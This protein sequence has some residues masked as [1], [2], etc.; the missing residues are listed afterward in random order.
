MAGEVARPGG[1]GAG[2][3]AQDTAA[4]A[5]AG[6]TAASAAA[7]GDLARGPDAARAALADRMR[8]AGLAGRVVEAAFRAVP[9]HLFVPEMPP[10]QAYQDEAFVI[11]SDAA[12]FPVSSSS[13]PAMMAIM[14]EQL[15][16][17]AGQRVLEI[18]SGTGYNAALIAH[19]VGAQC[20]VITVD[21]DPELASRAKASLAAAGYGGITVVCG[22]GGLGVAEHAP[23]DRI[24]L[25]VGAWD[26]APQ[27]LAQLA[28]GGR[29]VLPLS[30]RGIQLSVALERADD[31]HW[32][33]RSAFRCGFIKMGG[34]FS[35]PESFVP[36]G[37]QPGWRAAADDERRLDT[38]ALHQA[39]TGPGT[40][41]PTGLRPASL[42]EAADLDLWLTLTEPDLLRLTL[43]DA[44]SGPLKRPPL[45]PMGGLARPGGPDGPL[46]VAAV[47]PTAGLPSFSSPPSGLAPSGPAEPEPGEPGGVPAAPG[48][49]LRGHGPGGAVLAR[50]LAERALAWQELGRPGAGDLRLAV[51]PPG[52][53]AKAA[54]SGLLI[55][56]GHARIAVDWAGLSRA[57]VEADPLM[58]GSRAGESG[59]GESGAGESGAGESGAGES[60]AGESGAGE[61]LVAGPGAGESP[62]DVVR[63]GYDALSYRYRS[64]DAGQGRYGPWIAE[65][66]ARIPARAAVLDVGCGCGV[67]V[68]RALAAA[69]HSVTGIDISEVQIR[70]ARRLVP[71]GNFVRADAISVR[72]PA[73]SFDAIVCLYAMIHLPL[74]EQPGLIGRM[75]AWLR[76]AGWLL[77]IAGQDAWTGSEENW[78]GGQATMWWSQADASSY[79]AWLREAGLEIVS[80]AFVPE[81][82]GGHALFWAR[83]PEAAS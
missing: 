17:S 48:I 33:S 31:G 41:V 70:R 27:W 12:G 6:D 2:P 65:L 52:I 73:A 18:G 82:D 49:V 67:P 51:Y 79:R 56:R 50:Y 30:V 83:R 10:E 71:A 54:E 64:D 8:D 81:G 68:S 37:P 75:A 55:E 32:A 76:P 25:T 40:D 60:G 57:A 36:V 16:L 9:R 44:Q 28:P 58:A 61:S 11:K 74:A 38:R 26:I 24:I 43:R 19:I 34:A 15:G 4:S 80:T 66:L 42:A 14:L 69:G 3:A 62:T 20:D 63:R 78:L 5:A 39:L 47:W 77:V 35:G 21:I 45:L 22:D 29:L 59:A 13:Q 23:Y 53:P 1:T 46:G 7:G 72:L